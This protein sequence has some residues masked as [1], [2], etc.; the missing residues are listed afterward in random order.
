MR[1]AP[2]ADGQVRYEAV[3]GIARAQRHGDGETPTRRQPPCRK[4]AT[5]G[6]DLVDLEKQGIA[7]L[8]A[9]CPSVCEPSYWQT[10]SSPTISRSGRAVVRASEAVEVIFIESVFDERERELGRQR[11]VVV[12]DIR[13][14]PQR[15]FE[16][17]TCPGPC[18]RRRWRRHRPPVASCRRSRQPRPPPASPSK[19]S[20]VSFR[21]GG[22][23]RLRC[24]ARHRI[25]RTASL[26]GRSWSPGGPRAHRRTA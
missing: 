17:S 25:G 12:D 10:R 1:R 15:S 18:H 19:A 5:H 13:A 22:Q 26:R 2:E 7:C 9:G 16:G 24:P 20:R 3:I 23:A 14:R 6:A 8:A 21:G 4:G 11:R